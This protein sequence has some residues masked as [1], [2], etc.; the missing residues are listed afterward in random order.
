MTGVSCR[1]LSQT[2]PMMTEK[3]WGYSFDYERT[4]NQPQLPL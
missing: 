3:D 1:H 2:L 4:L